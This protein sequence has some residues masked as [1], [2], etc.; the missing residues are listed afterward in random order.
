MSGL[1]RHSRR[2]SRCLSHITRPGEPSTPPRHPPIPPVLSPTHRATVLVAPTPYLPSPRQYALTSRRTIS[3]SPTRRAAKASSEAGPSKK[4]NINMDNFPPERIRRVP[5]PF[6]LT[7][8]QDLITSGTLLH[9]E[10]SYLSL[11]VIF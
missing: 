7:S 6:C 10:N 1:I 2:C 4:R 11:C 9:N 3:T 8:P 5:A